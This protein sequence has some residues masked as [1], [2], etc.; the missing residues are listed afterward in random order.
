[1]HRQVSHQNQNR[2]QS[3]QEEQRLY[4]QRDERERA[5]QRAYS[6]HSRNLR[7]ST[8]G[9]DWQRKAPAELYAHQETHYW[10]QEE[11]NNQSNL[12]ESQ[13]LGNHR[14]LGHLYGNH[15]DLHYSFYQMRNCVEED[16]PAIRHNN[17][18]SRSS[19]M[20]TGGRANGYPPLRSREQEV[21]SAYQPQFCYTP[22]TYI[23]LRDYISVEEDELYCFNPASFNRHDGN[24]PPTPS[25]RAPSPLYRDDAPY[26]ILNAVE[27]TE[28]ITAIFMGFQQAQDDSCPGQDFEGSLKAELVIIEDNDDNP[29]D[30]NKEEKK[31]L[32]GK[33]QPTGGSANGKVLEGETKR[34]VR[35]GIRKIQKK[36]KACCAVC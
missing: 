24:L 34:W 19:S 22:A 31:S 29:G 17:R 1:M 18:I 12:R 10:R 23:P 33:G 11:R 3:R 13:H 14:G 30:A 28:P 5:Y 26:T 8:L 20:G 21:A 2:S 32:E 4:N 9:R 6:N 27:T 36:Q 16:R 15:K 35:P 25:D 7:C